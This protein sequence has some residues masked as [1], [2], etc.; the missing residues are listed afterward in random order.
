MF[1]EQYFNALDEKWEP[2]LS[3]IKTTCQESTVDGTN[4]LKNMFQM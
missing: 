4:Y 2:T 1:L 3:L